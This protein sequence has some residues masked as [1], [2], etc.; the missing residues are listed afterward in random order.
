M[1]LDGYSMLPQ[2]VAGTTKHV[3]REKVMDTEHRD[4]RNLP[5]SWRHC[6]GFRILLARKPDCRIAIDS[7]RVVG[8]RV[9]CDSGT[10]FVS[11]D[12]AAGLVSIENGSATS[13]WN[14]A[15]VVEIKSMHDR[16]LWLRG[17]R[18]LDYGYCTTQLNKE[19]AHV[20]CH[21]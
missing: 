8:K 20:V 5:H 7:V 10:V 14:V 9:R 13:S 12:V 4:F 18:T 19:F 21:V 16:L 6:G 2:Y 3:P 15:D 11:V 17:A 1:A